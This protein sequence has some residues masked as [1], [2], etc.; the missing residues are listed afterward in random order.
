MAQNVVTAI[1]NDLIKPY[2]KILTVLLVLV[3]FLMVSYYA[4]KWYVSPIIE[5]GLTGDISNENTRTGDATIYFFFADWC[6]HCKKAHP[7]WDN[8]KNSIAGTTVNNYN[9]HPLEVDCSDGNDPRI[10]KYSVNGYPTVVL[11]KDGKTIQLDA[12]ITK[13]NL[14]QFIANI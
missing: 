7:E 9:I 2:R 14:E 12:R 4:Y 8:F 6:P 10:Q 13:D 1:Y 3:I 5:E 11:E